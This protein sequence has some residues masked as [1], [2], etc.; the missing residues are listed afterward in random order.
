MDTYKWG[1][2]VGEDKYG[3]KYYQNDYYFVGRNRWVVYNDKV[4][5][6]Y[7]ASMIPAEWHNWMHYI[8]DDPPTEN[9]RVQHKW[10]IDHRENLSGSNMCY[11]P[12][13]TTK[14]KIE[15]WQP[16]GS[17]LKIGPSK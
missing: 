1:K 14:T 3:N 8:C 11:I 16:Q 5:L 2:L 17:Q 13:S 15:P 10:M 12:Y 7:D 6:D 9:P 4:F